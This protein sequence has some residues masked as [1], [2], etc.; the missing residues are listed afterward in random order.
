MEMGLKC[1]RYEIQVGPWD[2]LPKMVGLTTPPA[3]CATRGASQ[4]VM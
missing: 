3:T 2:G 4:T 1:V